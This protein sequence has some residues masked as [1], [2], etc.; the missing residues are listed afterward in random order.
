MTQNQ[1]RIAWGAAVC[2]V[3]S[4]W[5]YPAVIGPGSWFA[6]YEI[7]LPRER[8]PHL[9]GTWKGSWRFIGDG[10]TID[11]MIVFNPEGTGSWLDDGQSRTTF[12]WGTERGVLYMRYKA[13]DAWAGLHWTY[14]LDQSGGRVRLVDQ[15][16]YSLIAGPM[17]R[18]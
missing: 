13:V 8:D 5:I 4:P 16:E 18:E 14:R 7:R 9:F 12:A 3:L 15:S 11:R 6:F 1:R 2:A 10:Q 17:R